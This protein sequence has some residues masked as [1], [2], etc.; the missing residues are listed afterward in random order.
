MKRTTGNAARVL[1]GQLIGE[2]LS[3]GVV[4]SDSRTL[5]PSSLFVA[6]R[7]P[8]FD[9]ADFVAA[10]AARGAVAALV[11]RRVAAG[12]T[13]IVVPDALRALQQLGLADVYGTSLVPLYVM[14]VAYPLI[15]DELVEFCTGKT[16]VLMVEEGAPEYIEHSLNTI[17]RRRDI[18][19]RVSGKDVLQMGGEYT[20]P[21]LVKGL[22][23]FIGQ[24]ARIAPRARRVEE[25][26][27]GLLRRMREVA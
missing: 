21:V 10:A 27:V 15:D 6:L 2:D 7:G 24:H 9:G 22:A 5:E 23:A 8:N 25:R 11:E 16:A 17:L 13:Q 26:A 20:A 4:S 3:Y 18:Q 1:G 14:N 12:L 19:T